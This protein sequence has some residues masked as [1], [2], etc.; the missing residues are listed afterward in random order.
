MNFW[1]LGLN[2]F[3]FR[4]YGLDFFDNIVELIF[5]DKI[6]FVEDNFVCKSNLFNALIFGTLLFF[7][8]QMLNDMFSINNS[9]DSIKYGMIGHILIHKE[10]LSY[11]SRVG[12]AS[13]FNDDGI[14]SSFFFD[15]KFF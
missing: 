4:V 14:K 6:S 13:G 11:R 5:I 15:Q 12:H 8:L 2:D 10:S 7:L 9:N 1:K 3:A